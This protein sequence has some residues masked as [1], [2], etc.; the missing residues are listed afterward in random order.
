MNVA[1]FEGEPAARSPRRKRA[2][3]DQVDGTGELSYELERQ[4]LGS[5]LNWP[6]SLPLAVGI[7]SD[8]FI[9]LHH[10]AIWDAL[11]T[12]HSDGQVIDLVSVFRRID[13]AGLAKRFLNVGGVEAYL[14]GLATSV[15][16]PDRVSD[17]VRVLRGEVSRRK[18]S[19]AAA[20]PDSTDK[21]K[22]QTADLMALFAGMEGEAFRS[23][24][25][26]PLV[27]LRDKDARKTVSLQQA[28][29]S[30]CLAYYRKTGMAVGA[31][32]KEEVTNLLQA[33]ADDGPKRRTWLRIAEHNGELYLDLGDESWTVIRITPNGWEPLAVSPVHF[34]RPAAMLAL[35]MPERGG[36]LG[37]LFE[38]VNIPDRPSQ[39]LA[40]GWLVGAFR[41]GR[42]MPLLA[43]TGKQGCAKSTTAKILA[44][45]LDPKQTA[46]RVRPKDE[47]TVMV[48]AMNAWVLAYDNLSSIPE[49]LSDL[50]CCL[51]TGASY[52][53]RKLYTDQEESVMQALRPV[54]FTS[55]EDIAKRSDL[56]DRTVVLHLPTIEEDKRRTEEEVWADFTAAHGRILG[57]VLDALSGALRNL[58][59]VR[60]E[61]LPRMADFAKWAIAAEHRLGLDDGEFLSAYAENRLDIHAQALESC[62]LVDPLDRFMSGTTEW[63]GTAT[64]LLGELEQRANKQQREHKRWPKDETRL[65]GELQRIAPNLRVAGFEL[66][67]F[68][69]TSRHRR[70]LI[71][72]QKEGDANGVRLQP[73]HKGQ[74]EL[75]G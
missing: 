13:A 64:D 63:T 12:L 35:P 24:E 43:V 10:G 47:Q 44:S 23:H 20:Q 25:D 55:I 61:G 30:L 45:I 53:A 7:G 74:A 4:F 66:K 51:S 40:L 18:L 9:A 73:R 58:P 5:F 36:Q 41:P 70:R 28:V 38:L 2:G 68:R 26:K 62:P 1:P 48:S 75:V 15:D 31:R 22:N 65:S 59:S 37:E 34:I 57:A 67:Q 39:A 11:V 21:T 19:M 29:R 69:E 50:L 54:V 52:P 14:A 8:S 17:L 71:Q 6:D 60:P 32:S 72:I 3:R 33:M 16:S 42:P 56:L 46:L 49:W 27:C